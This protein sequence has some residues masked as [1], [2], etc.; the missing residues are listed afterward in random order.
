MHSI[1]GYYLVFYSVLLEFLHSIFW[2]FAPR[3]KR[4]N[5]TSVFVTVLFCKFFSPFLFI[6]YYIDKLGNRYSFFPLNILISCDSNFGWE[7]TVRADKW[8]SDLFLQ[9]LTLAQL[10]EH[11]FYTQNILWYVLMLQLVSRLHDLLFIIYFR[12]TSFV[13]ILLRVT[14]VLWWTF[15]S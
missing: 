7:S 10:L 8:Q 1:V 9:N 3:C 15:F 4:R 2:F 5:V 6:D 14:L 12:T 13:Q 11:S